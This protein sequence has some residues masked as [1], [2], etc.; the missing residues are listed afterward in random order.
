MVTEANGL[1]CRMTAF[2]DVDTKL[3]PTWDEHA[4]HEKS[5]TVIVCCV[6]HPS[7]LCELGQVHVPLM[8]LVSVHPN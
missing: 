5:P 3:N 6:M 8:P 4:M 1:S 2:A 7:A